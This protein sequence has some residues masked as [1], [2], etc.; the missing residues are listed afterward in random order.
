MAGR[1]PTEQGPDIEQLL[2]NMFAP[3][4]KA[5]GMEMATKI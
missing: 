1:A 2:K 4:F 5:E 3:S